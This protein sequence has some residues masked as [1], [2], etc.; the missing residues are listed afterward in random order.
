MTGFVCLHCNTTHTHKSS[1]CFS[2]QGNPDYE[3]SEMVLYEVMLMLEGGMKNRALVHIKNFESKI[4]DVL[5][6][7]ETK[8]ELN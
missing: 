2:V 6:I 3:F 4:C 5:F 8:G 1:R 7:M